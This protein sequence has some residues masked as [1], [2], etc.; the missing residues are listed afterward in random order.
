V[1]K[2]YICV[3]DAGRTSR[4]RD[5]IKED[6]VKTMSDLGSTFGFLFYAGGLRLRL[7]GYLSKILSSLPLFM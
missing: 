4:K 2:R 7:W 5:D 1:F 3:Y 6:E